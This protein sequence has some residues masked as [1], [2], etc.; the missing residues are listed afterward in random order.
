MASLG[1]RNVIIAAA[2]LSFLGLGVQPA[3]PEWGAM[4]SAGWDVCHNRSLA[5]AFTGSFYH[6]NS[7][8]IQL[9]RR[10]VEGRT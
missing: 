4:L 3:T 9:L 2:G 8:C 10:R 7:F 1:I 5:D 6:D